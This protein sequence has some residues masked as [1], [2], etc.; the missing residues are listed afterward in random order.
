MHR[1][2]K[3]KDRRLS[4]ILNKFVSILS[5]GFNDGF[6]PDNIPGDLKFKTWASITPKT[7][8]KTQDSD[9]DNVNIT[10]EIL[11]E[12]HGGRKID[13]KDIVTY[14]D[15]TFHIIYVF[16]HNEDDR[17]YVLKAEEKF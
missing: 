16:N 12:F 1:R 11:I 17:L 15:R 9:R 6:S 4:S 13:Q 7:G 3:K 10:H 2:R 8:K 5:P 14:G